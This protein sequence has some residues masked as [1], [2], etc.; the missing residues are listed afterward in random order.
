MSLLSRWVGLGTLQLLGGAHRDVMPP[1]AERAR[2]AVLVAELQITLR[3]AEYL[4]ARVAG[5]SRDL[6]RAVNAKTPGK[7]LRLL[8]RHCSPDVMAPGPERVVAC[9]F[10][11][12]TLGYIARQVLEGDR[13]AV[14]R[15]PL[16]RVYLEPLAGGRLELVDIGA[17]LAAAKGTSGGRRYFTF[18]DHLQTADLGTIGNPFLGRPHAF[19]LLEVIVAL[20]GE[21]AVLGKDGERRIEAG[22]PDARDAGPVLA[23][24]C[25]VLEDLVRSDPA[26]LLSWNRLN[27]ARLEARGDRV[28]RAVGSARALLV[29]WRAHDPT[30]PDECFQTL[31]GALDEIAS[32]CAAGIEPAHVQAD[33]HA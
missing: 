10:H 4:S 7:A 2:A 16:T 15:T 6:L 28:A 31:R 11:R 29:A 27:A 30:L 8:A 26:G 1:R 3:Q 25:E 5:H 33:L 14:L 18:P 20:R 21:L 23:Q 17:V 9:A 32:G 13:V 24:L 19:T 22:R 12:L